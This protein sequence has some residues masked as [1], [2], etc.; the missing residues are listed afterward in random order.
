LLALGEYGLDLKRLV[1]K[2]FLQMI[3]MN[4]A[5]GTS[6]NAIGISS[7][8]V[9]TSNNAIGT[10]NNAMGTSNRNRSPLQ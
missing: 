7:N 9:G 10:S 8:A 3:L 5:I 6:S 4:N 1:L 2:L